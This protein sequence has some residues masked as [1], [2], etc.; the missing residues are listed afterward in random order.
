M[1]VSVLFVRGILA[2]LHHQGLSTPEILRGLNVSDDVLSDLRARIPCGD[3]ERIIGRALQL[4]NDPGLGLSMGSRAPE[5]ML[6]L[7]GY[8]L[9][10]CR[11]LREAFGA[12][13]RYAAL[14]VNDAGWGLT[15]DGEHA[16]FS[17]RCPLPH[18][19]GSRFAAEYVLAMALRIA[20][21]FVPVHDAPV[22]RI[23]FRHEA[24][25]YEDRYARIFQ[26]AVGFDQPFDGIVF[27][28]RIL[29]V[30]QFHADEQ[31]N[32]ALRDTAERLLSELDRPATLADRLRGILRSETVLVTVEVDK[33]ARSVGLTRR[34]LR[35]RL[36]AEG[37]SFTMLVDEARCRLACEELR[38]EESIRTISERVGYSEPSAFHRAF[39]R[40]TGQTP[41]EY[42]R[43]A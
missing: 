37:T 28:R 29:D 27:A 2:E 4:S 25:S 8:L 14:T 20:R 36:A 7:L 16:T 32:W 15:E 35:R 18:G 11:T 31:T 10:S 22:E 1:F 42:V 30:P 24:P 5:S 26:C 12:L 21:H 19:P 17:Y 43:G 6:Q 33:L 23:S 39:R 9:L 3:L 13:Q 34:S 38:R 41:S 40:W